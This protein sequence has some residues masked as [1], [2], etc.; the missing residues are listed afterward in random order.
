MRILYSVLLLGIS[1][2]A[3]VAQEVG[4]YRSNATGNWSSSA[5]WQ[6]WNGSI[7]VSA[8]S[9][10]TGGEDITI[11]AADTVTVDVAV[12]I[13]DTL[14]YQGHMENGANLTVADGGVFQYDRNAGSLPLDIT[15]AEGSVYYITGVTSTAPADRNQDFH[16]VVLNTDLS[17]NRDLGWAYN[18]IHG[19]VTILATSTGSSRW[20]M[21][22]PQ[23]DST[24][25]ITIM[26]NITQA[27]GAFSSQGTSNANSHLIVHTYGD[28]TVTGGNFSV[29]RG[30]QGGSGTTLWYLYGENFSMEN[31]TTQNSNASGATFIFARQGRQNLTLGA[32]NTL[33][34]L[35]IE[36]DSGAQL[37]LGQSRVSGS[38]R[39]VVNDWASVATEDPGG[40]DSAVVSDTLTK[41]FSKKGGYIFNGSAAQVTGT[42][43]PDTVGALVVDNASGVELSQGV[44]V[45]DRL[46]I[47]DGVLNNDNGLTIGPDVTIGTGDPDGIVDFSTQLSS[48]LDISGVQSFEFVGTTAQVTSTA[49]PATV[50]NLTIDNPTTVTL[51]QATHV[52]GILRLKAGV[53][54]NTIGLTL[55]PDAQIIEEGGTLAVLVSAPTATS[56]LPGSFFVDQN[57]PNPFNPSTRIR[58]GINTASLVTVG[59]Y[60]LLGQRVATLFEGRKEPGT[61]ELM[62]DAV[63][64]PSGVYLLRVQAGNQTSVR[65]MVLMK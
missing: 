24:I 7:W 3:L 19:D 43:L 8:P 63:N 27:S 50:V 49:M 9:A 12:S 25:I 10:P 11:Q 30:S 1:A 28:I 51:S 29:A 37:Y 59:V 31:T 54:D 48:P 18:T 55:G 40:L 58:Y 4:D 62:F 14:K 38:G 36:V 32:G 2:A 20:Q 35:P 53:L 60:N 33:S 56:S 44:H 6:I 15:W 26:G 17:S 16:H 61:H 64:L 45:T 46:V 65:R 41:S 21:T 42:T 13:T 57:F 34:A 52:T 22:A 23:T 39:F 47:K 5:T